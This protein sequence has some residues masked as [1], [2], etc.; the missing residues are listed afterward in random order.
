MGPVSVGEVAAVL[1]I[2]VPICRALYLFIE[3]QRKVLK[4]VDKK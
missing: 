4:D 3:L 2:V 1:L